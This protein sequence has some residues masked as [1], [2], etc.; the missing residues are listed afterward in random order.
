LRLNNEYPN[1]LKAIRSDNETDFRNAPFDQF[2]LE[3][4]VDQQFS[5]PRVPQKNRVME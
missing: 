1:C 4:S 5:V 3:H 2:F